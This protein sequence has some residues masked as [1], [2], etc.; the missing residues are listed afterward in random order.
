MSSVPIFLWVPVPILGS[1]LLS[2]ACVALAAIRPCCAGASAFQAGLSPGNL[3]CSPM[4]ALLFSRHNTYLQEC[5]GQREPTY[6]LNIHDLK[7]L[8]LRFAMEQSFSADTGGGGRESNIHLIPYIIHTVLYVLNTSVSQPRG[9][10][11]AG[12]PVPLCPT[13]SPLLGSR[14]L[15]LWTVSYP[16]GSRNWARPD[17]QTSLASTAL[18]LPLLMGLGALG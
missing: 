8:F 2:S 4:F 13:R 14:G 10:R 17:H 16:E 15:C 5:T 6:Q 7:L 18:S 3:F 1:A 9:Q 11:P 12:P